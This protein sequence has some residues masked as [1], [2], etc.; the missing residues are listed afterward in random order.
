MKI[1][2]CGSSPRSGSRS[3]WARIKNVNGA[4]RL[5]NIWNFFDEIR[6][7]SCRDWWPWTKPGYITMTRRQINNQWSGGIAAHTATKNAEFRN[8]LAKFSPRFLGI[9]MVSSSLIIVQRPNYQRAVLLISAGAIECHFEGKSATGKSP[10]RSCSCMTMPRLTGHLQPR[11]NWPT[12]VSNLSITKPILRIWPRRTTTCSL[13]W[14][15]QL[16]VRH[17]SSDT[18]VIGAAETW[19][20]GQISEFFWVAYRS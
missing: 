7:I 10:R 4:S 2:T 19:L 9:K 3:A 1:W 5:S 20:D 15:K 13:D 14:K 11:R 12:W 16:K 18:E 6:M 8:P 17:F